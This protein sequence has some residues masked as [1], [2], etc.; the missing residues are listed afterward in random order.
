M[1]A[2]RRVAEIIGTGMVIDAAARRIGAAPDPV[3]DVAAWHGTQIGVGCGK[4]A[5]DVILT[6]VVAAIYGVVLAAPRTTISGAGVMVVA[7]QWVEGTAM[8]LH[9][10]KASKARVI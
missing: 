1:T 7:K 3:L 8:H 4:E 9:V 2:Q 6:F 10:A 5:V